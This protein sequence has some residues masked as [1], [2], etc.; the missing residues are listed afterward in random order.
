MVTGIV[1]LKLVLTMIVR[2]ANLILFNVTH[3]DDKAVI[4]SNDFGTQTK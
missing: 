4:Y 2:R 1:R 3:T